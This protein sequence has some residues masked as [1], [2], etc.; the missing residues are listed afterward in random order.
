MVSI[1]FL[2]VCLKM[3]YLGLRRNDMGLNIEGGCF[4]YVYTFLIVFSD[5]KIDNLK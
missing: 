2:N 5:N 3:V 4:V 1:Q